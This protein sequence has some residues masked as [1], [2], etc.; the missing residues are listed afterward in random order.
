[1]NRY[2]HIGFSPSLGFE[3]FLFSG[4]IGTDAFC[5]GC[6]HPFSGK[7][8]SLEKIKNEFCDQTSGMDN[9]ITLSNFFL[10][11]LRVFEKTVNRLDQGRSHCAIKS[12]VYGIGMAAVFLGLSFYLLFQV[13]K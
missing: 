9:R 5:R 2:I 7:V 4:S 3:A 1:L 12:L 13:K 6:L 11:G 10:Q 8:W